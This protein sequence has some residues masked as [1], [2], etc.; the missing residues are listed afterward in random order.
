MT[1]GKCLCISQHLNGLQK[2]KLNFNVKFLIEG[3]E[4]V[5]SDN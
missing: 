1:K 5:G 3:E 2:N 4:E